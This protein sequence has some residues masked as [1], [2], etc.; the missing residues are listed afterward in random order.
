MTASVECSA[1]RMFARDGPGLN[2]AMEGHFVSAYSEVFNSAH[3]IGYYADTF[4]AAVESDAGSITGTCGRCRNLDHDPRRTQVFPYWVTLGGDR[5]L[6]PPAAWTTVGGQPA[7]L[8]CEKC[9]PRGLT[10]GRPR[11][12]SRGTKPEE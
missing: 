11:D 12:A 8:L 3:T 6:I 4:M 10:A 9:V 2:R 5:T 1:R 7:L